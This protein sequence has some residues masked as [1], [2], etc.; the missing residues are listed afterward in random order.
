VSHNAASW[1]IERRGSRTKIGPLVAATRGTNAVTVRRV[2]ATKTRLATQ[3]AMARAER[4]RRTDDRHRLKTSDRVLIDRATRGFE[5]LQGKWKV[6]LIVAMARGIRRPSRLHACLPGISKKVMTDCLRGLERDGLVARRIY[7]Q[8]PAR[9][10]YSLT[11]LGWT[12]TNAIVAVSEWSKDHSGDV[13]RARSDYWLR[14]IE[15][16]DVPPST[17]ETMSFGSMASP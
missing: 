1:R 3:G 14:G 2:L 10:E 6:H 4:A 16:D 9:V 5:V 12:I 11:P 17:H 7:A 13:T 15:T 8:V